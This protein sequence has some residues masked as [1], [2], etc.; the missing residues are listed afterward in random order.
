[1]QVRSHLQVSRLCSP[2]N[3]CD[4]YASRWHRKVQADKKVEPDEKLADD[5]TDSKVA[6]S[7]RGKRAIIGHFDPVVCKQFK[8]IALDQDKSSQA[9]LAEALN[10]LFQS[11]GKKPIA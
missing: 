11:Y 7:R 10:L 8:Q 6:P 2:H 3:K 5:K 4:G 9:L 1:M